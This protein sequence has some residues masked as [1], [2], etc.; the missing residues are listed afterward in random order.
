[1]NHQILTYEQTK[2]R[3]GD[4]DGIHTTPLMIEPF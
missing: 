2:K 3:I 4:A 1:M